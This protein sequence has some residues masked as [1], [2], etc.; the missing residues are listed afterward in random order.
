MKN[1][2]LI[3]MTLVAWNLFGY[4]ENVLDFYFSCNSFESNHLLQSS[5]FSC[6]FFNFWNSSKFIMKLQKTAKIISFI[7]L[8]EIFPKNKRNLSSFINNH[9]T[10][11]KREWKKLEKLPAPLWWFVVVISAFFASFTII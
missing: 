11:M 2:W 9:K 4:Y 6:E 5:Q 1:F 7:F 8:S 10:C 3:V